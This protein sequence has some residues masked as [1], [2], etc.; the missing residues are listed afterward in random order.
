M[1]L[2]D[3]FNALMKD[4]VMPQSLEKA[5][6]VNNVSQEIA[7]AWDELNELMEII[8]FSLF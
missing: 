2:T 8:K 5:V 3:S 1:D 6:C 4:C 7:A